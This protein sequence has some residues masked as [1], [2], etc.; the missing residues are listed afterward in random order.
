MEEWSSAYLQKNIHQLNDMQSYVKRRLTK[1][2]LHSNRLALCAGS[3]EGLF[4]FEHYYQTFPSYDITS[5]MASNG[6]DWQER[7]GLPSMLWREQ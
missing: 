5:R 7:A 6:C 2:R 1:E 4:Y 3:Q